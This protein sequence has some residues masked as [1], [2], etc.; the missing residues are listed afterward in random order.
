MRNKK[1]YLA[2]LLVIAYVSMGCADKSRRTEIE[3]RKAALIHKQ[4]SSLADAQARLA[5][6]DSLLEIAKQQHDAQHK[7]V[8]D[9]STKMNNN[10]PEVKKLNELRAHRDSLQAEWQTLGAKIRYIKQQ[11]EKK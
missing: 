7:L 5:E 10:S 3:Q 11:K 2:A 8:M 6:V 4:D 9:N 1:I